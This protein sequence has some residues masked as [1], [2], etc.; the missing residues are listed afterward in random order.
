MMF[1]IDQVLRSVPNFPNYSCETFGYPERLIR[2]CD[3][4][5]LVLGPPLHLYYSFR[6]PKSCEV[7]V[8]NI[9]DWATMSDVIEIFERFGKI[10]SVELSVTLKRTTVKNRYQVDTTNTSV[11]CNGWARVTYTSYDGAQK[12]LFSHMTR[13]IS[14]MFPPCAPSSD[15]VL[16]IFSHAME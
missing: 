11:S 1:A 5:V 6:P 8:S 7:H 12:A 16:D 2:K 14:G 3:D 9:P 10:F 13:R 4:S 15:N